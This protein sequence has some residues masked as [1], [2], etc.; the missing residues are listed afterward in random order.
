MPDDF[1]GPDPSVSRIDLGPR[2]IPSAR[3]L[4]LQHDALLP[5]LGPVP[6]SIHDDGSASDRSPYAALAG[7]VSLEGSFFH[8][9]ARFGG[10]C[11]TFAT[12]SHG[13]V[14]TMSMSY[15][16]VRL[17]VLHPETLVVQA[18][19]ELP[20][21][22]MP[23][24]FRLMNPRVRDAMFR[25]VTGGAYF[26]IDDQ[27]RV[28]VAA[29]DERIWIVRTHDGT[30]PVAELVARI[31]LG[32]DS[33][34]DALVAVVPAWP[35]SNAEPKRYFYATK[36]GIVGLVELVSVAAPA[37]PRD[38]PVAFT[39]Q[40]TE[41]VDESDH[42]GHPVIGNGL[43][44]N[45][46]GLFLVSCRKLYRYVSAP[47]GLKRAGSFTYATAKERKGP[48]P[49]RF[50]IGSGTTPTLM[51]DRFV[52]I[53]DDSLPMKVFVCEQRD[54]A[55][56]ASIEVFGKDGC[57]ELSFIAYGSSI[58]ITNTYGYTN[59]TSW[60]GT[61]PGGMA[62][63]DVASTSPLRLAL[64]PS[65]GANA[66]DTDTGSSTPKLSLGDGLVYAYALDRR[67]RTDHRWRLFGVDFRTGKRTLD[68]EVFDDR[69]FRERHDNG[70]GI[71]SLLPNGDVFVGM[72]RG[73]IR[74][75]GRR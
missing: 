58:V 40:W 73:F 15:K 69:R 31:E 63:V 38:E 6:N 43:A 27:D 51:D 8:P 46:N 61:K 12:T 68:V 11:T 56:S 1:E 33:K 16:H 49:G 44:A 74:I 75:R 18:T 59:P 57:C 30:R 17:L 42:T 35:T 55:S 29:A 9:G 45:R 66:S 70:W 13:S 72:W 25:D 52:A 28:V 47:E 24:V 62:K 71:L 67:S 34:S 19:L 4:A 20:R 53:G 39:R 54:L 32:V 7:S 36:R 10:V 60:D 3:P 2:T 64:D 14:V 65:W 22:S 5:G 50:N 21:R 26:F 41:R 48:V 23:S 37:T